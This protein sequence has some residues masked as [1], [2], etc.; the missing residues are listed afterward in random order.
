M[1]SYDVITNSV[2]LSTAQSLG[3]LWRTIQQWIMGNDICSE[4]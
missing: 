2:E 3:L 4:L 1:T